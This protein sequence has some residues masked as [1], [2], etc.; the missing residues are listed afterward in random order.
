MALVR[1]LHRQGRALGVELGEDGLPKKGAEPEQMEVQEGWSNSMDACSDGYIYSPT[2]MYGEVRRIH[3]ESGEIETV[4]PGGDIQFPSAIDVNDATGMVYSTEF[5][6]GNITKIDLKNQTSRVIAKFPPCTDNVACSDDTKI[7]RIFGSSFV[8]DLI[9]KVSEFGDLPRVVSMGGLH[10]ESIQCIGNRVFIKDMG[11]VMEYFPRT[12]KHESF[13]WGNFWVFADGKSLIIAGAMAES[14]PNR[15]I[16][17]DLETRQPTRDIYDLPHLNDAVQIGDE[18]YLIAKK[19]PKEL[20]GPEVNGPKST[21]V[22]DPKPSME[23]LVTEDWEILLIDKNGNRESVYQNAGLSCFAQKDCDTYVNDNAAGEILQVGKDG[24][25][26]GKPVVVA[27]GLKSP[28]GIAVGIDGNLLVM[29]ANEE[30]S[31]N[32]R[33]KVVFGRSEERQVNC[34]SWPSGYLPQVESGDVHGARDG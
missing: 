16:V 8:A 30:D 29:E 15:L 7:P 4:W 6:L 3:P 5:H 17:M 33:R 11:R 10:Y 22:A 25:W 19:I 12:G 21:Y 27:S 24:K 31:H 14:T 26:L 1:R 18:L 28:E 20:R 9:M 32:G 2:N 34:Y 23:G 13:A